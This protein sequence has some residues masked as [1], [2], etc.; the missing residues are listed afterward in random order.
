MPQTLSSTA[1]EAETNGTKN[2][3]VAE[4]NG[5]KKAQVLSDFVN[6]DLEV[7]RSEYIFETPVL[8]RMLCGLLTDKR[9]EPMVHLQLNIIEYVVA[10]MSLLFYLNMRE[11]PPA[12]YVRNI[13]GLLYVV[14]NTLLFEE[15]FILMLHYY[16]HR[17]IYDR[18]YTFLN[19]YV[20]WLMTPFYGMPSGVYKLHH[21]VMHHTEN[22]HEWDISSTEFYQRDN[23]FHFLAYYIRFF[24]LI[25][26]ELPLYC[27]KSKRLDRLPT[28]LSGIV[29]WAGSIFFLA[30]YVNFWAT[31]WVFIVPYFVCFLALS[32]GNW[33][34]HMF[35]DPTRPESN[36]AL[37][38]NCIDHFVNQRTFNDGYHVIHHY[39]AR[40]HWSEMPKHF[41]SEAVQKRH[42]EEG[43]L[44]FRDIHF[45]DVGILVMTGRLHKLAEHYV[46]L[47]S[48]ETAPTLDAVVENMRAWLKP[49]PQVKKHGSAVKKTD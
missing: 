44:T 1:R 11:N 10:G 17:P 37:T 3:K 4:T 45:F 14:G 7:A 22:N 27:V 20:N 36:Y 32:F 28:I 42:L 5:S 47:G 9:D 33:S 25:I 24:C 49:M 40:L 48:K 12:L 31:L 21:V 46:H 18:K 29:G 41:H 8:S 2:A 19:N 23:I 26:F 35:V 30:K 13:V 39:N 15:R 34:Q 16:S 6:S 38:Y 43:A